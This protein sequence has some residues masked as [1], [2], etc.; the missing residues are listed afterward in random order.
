VIVERGRVDLIYDTHLSLSSH[1]V[2]RLPVACISQ[3]VSRPFDAG[4]KGACT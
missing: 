4:V 2:F 3:Y 1:A